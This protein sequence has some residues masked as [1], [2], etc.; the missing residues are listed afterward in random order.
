[1][2]DSAMIRVHLVDDHMLVRD[3]IR[4]LLER[5]PGMCVVAMSSCG[6]EAYSDYF[7]HHPD[8]MLLDVTMPGESGL[9]VL[10]RILLRDSEARILMLSMLD[11]EVVA[12]KAIEMGAHGYLSKGVPA[13]VLYD[14]VSKVAAG[15]MFI[16]ANI[17]QR[18]ALLNA[19]KGT[20]AIEVLSDREFEVFRLLAQG[21]GVSDIANTLHLSPKTVGAHRTRIMEKLACNNVAELARIAIRQGVINP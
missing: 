9:S 20:S 11:D 2:M 15:E 7:E 8:V 17:A 6:E 12:L 10:K 1:M 13:G 4:G 18:M 5:H 16:E 14:A 19:R 21:K 3:G